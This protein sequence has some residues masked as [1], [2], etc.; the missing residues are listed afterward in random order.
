MADVNV[1]IR[2]E[3]YKGDSLV[4]EE[5][6]AQDVI[7]I[8]KLASSHLRL[9][10]ETVSRMHAVIETTG[11]DEIHVVDL[12]STRGTTVNGERIT[13]ARL[14]SGDEVMFGDCRVVV[15]FMEGAPAQ[16]T[17]PPQAAWG[18]RPG[19][20]AAP[21]AAYAPPPAAAYAPPPQQSYAPPPG[22]QQ[23]PPQAYMAP[24]SFAGAPGAG[25]EVEVH[26]GTRAMEVQT[27]FRGV[28]TGTRHL[29]NP[30][31]KSTHSQGTSMLYAGAAILAVAIG[32]FIYTA[33][34]VGSEKAQYELWQAGGREAKSFF[35]KERSP[36]LPVIVFGGIVGG[37]ALTYMGM[38][39]R[40]K[41]SPNFIIGSDGDVDAPV[42]P[43]YVPSSSH[44]LVAATGT[45][46]VVN[47]TPRMGG[48]VYVDGQ[49]YPLQQFIQQRGSSFS[50]PQNGS[51]RLD[52]G[53]TTFV[54]TATPRPRALEIPFFNWRWDEQVYSVGTSVALILFLLMIFAVPPDP[55]SL[56][57]DLFNSDNRFVKFLIK[58][59]EEK[60]EDI[61]E[62][63]KKKDDS[64]QGGKGKRHKGEEGKMGKKT[65]K[66]KEGL[67]GLKGPKDNPDPHLAKKLAEEQAKNAGILGVLK[68]T[69][70]SHIASIFGRDSALGNDAADVLGGLVGN[71]I[72]EAYGVGGLGLVGTG[73]GGGGTGEGTIGLGNLGTIGKGGGGGN[74]SG[75]GRGAGGLGGRRAHAPDVI[76]GQA[77]VRGSLDKEIIRRIIRR[78][79]NEVKYC[80]EQELTKKPE[81]GGRIMVQFTIA[82]SGQ[83]IASVLQNSTMGNA[84]VENCTVQAVR[85]WEFPKPLGGGIVIVSYPFVLTPAG[86]GGE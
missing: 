23:A 48:E 27:V 50:L 8:G 62:F 80:Y 44:P 18:G 65:S 73:S 49:T 7:K 3:I 61:P 28:V 32:A 10:D 20:F 45:D 54:I 31:G 38:K 58:P 2:F 47:V 74:G 71:Q 26:D 76:P 1:P 70:G 63:L 82:A 39:R 33:I 83:V 25:A 86:G 68:Q 64:Q 36:V 6:L 16:E 52:C 84:R 75:Y 4:R 17:P 19:G 72:G 59:P 46:Y 40:G 5:T 85:R 34:D 81:L 15:T 37:L 79:I 55:K 21:P 14:Q 13:K 77:N 66:N 12:G 24:P 42:S 35:W 30:E 51:A 53:E 29:F 60:E 41:T 69:E 43:D 11:P 67:Y 56:S 9:D 78:H 22:Y 57:L